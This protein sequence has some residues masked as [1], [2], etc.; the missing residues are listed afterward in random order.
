M[1]CIDQDPSDF[2]SGVLDPSDDPSPLT[3]ELFVSDGRYVDTASPY[4][5]FEINVS[6]ANYAAAVQF[7]WATSNGTASSGLHYTAGS[8][9]ITIAAG[10]GIAIIQITVLKPNNVS[11]TKTFNL[12]ISTPVNATINDGT[13]VGTI[14][15]GTQDPPPT[16]PGDNSSMT[17]W[18]GGVKV[19]YN[20]FPS[21]C[22]ECTGFSVAALLSS[23]AYLDKGTKV[24]YDAHELFSGSGGPICTTCPTGCFGWDTTRVL[25]YAKSTGGRVY[26][27]STRRKILD[28]QQIN[29]TDKPTL[30]KK[31]KNN[32]SWFGP[33]VMD[34][35]FFGYN[36]N[37]PGSDH[38]DWNNYG[39]S[40]V[41]GPKFL[42][43]EQQRAGYRPRGRHHPVLAR[44]WLGQRWSRVVALQPHQHAAVE[45]LPGLR[46]LH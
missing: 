45:E 36:K 39:M 41:S 34:S 24:T 9:H 27:G 21:H 29:A 11:G 10:S 23:H 19:V 37:S 7:D 18:P 1:A 42:R 13:G 5:E 12:T 38:T 31:I 2:S 20:E 30:L 6:P 28:W 14:K 4:M 35:S 33:V 16:D 40:R 17:V 32:I 25:A 15:Y 26:G 43:L 3:S 44:R 22:N 46:L 8:G